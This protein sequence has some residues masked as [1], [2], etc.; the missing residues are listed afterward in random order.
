MKGARRRS[1]QAG[2][3]SFGAAEQSLGLQNP[4]VRELDIVGD[5]DIDARGDQF[6]AHIGHA[7]QRFMHDDIAGFGADDGLEAE[8]EL[9]FA[10]IGGDWV[11]RKRGSV[12][13]GLQAILDPL[14]IAG[15]P[16]FSESA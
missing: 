3:G 10:A 7:Q 2:G 14:A 11:V 6:T 5:V 9:V 13:G 1:D 16:H 12:V 15:K 8:L 4:F